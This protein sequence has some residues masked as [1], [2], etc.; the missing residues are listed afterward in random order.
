[1]AKTVTRLI[2]LEILSSVGFNQTGKLEKQLLGI[3]V[4]TEPEIQKKR[5]LDISK[6]IIMIR[7]ALIEL[8]GD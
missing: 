8:L 2:Y 3:L 1:M 5:G 4:E 6:I 7:A